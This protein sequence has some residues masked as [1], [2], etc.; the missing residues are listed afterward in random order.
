[1]ARIN[2][3]IVAAFSFYDNL[4][5]NHFGQ[6]YLTC[7]KFQITLNTKA[8]GATARKDFS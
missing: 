3:Q 4:R 1:M 2:K 8:G 5:Q 7:S 6:N